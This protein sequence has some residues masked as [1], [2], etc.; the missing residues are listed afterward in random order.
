MTSTD[1]MMAMRWKGE[2]PVSQISKAYEANILR[3]IKSK[4]L[5]HVWFGWQGHAWI[6][7]FKCKSE[8]IN[9]NTNTKFISRKL[10]NKKVNKQNIEQKVDIVLDGICQAFQLK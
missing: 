4:P 9:Y 7:A 3:L 1:K 10:L 6:E 2:I 5:N 8:I